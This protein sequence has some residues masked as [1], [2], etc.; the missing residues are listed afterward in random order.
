MQL[1]TVFVGGEAYVREADTSRW[2]LKKPILCA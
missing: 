1:E 2:F